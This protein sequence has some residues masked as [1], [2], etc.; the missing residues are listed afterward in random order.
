MVVGYWWPRY[1]QWWL[2]FGGLGIDSGGAGFGYGGFELELEIDLFI[3]S[4][5]YNSNPIHG[6]HQ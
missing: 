1:R 6:I 2:G 3:L 5:Y 4:T